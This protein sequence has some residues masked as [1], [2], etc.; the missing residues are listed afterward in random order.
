MESGGNREIYLRRK[1]THLFAVQIRTSL[2]YHK[3]QRE[4]VLSGNSVLSLSYSFG[5]PWRK[6]EGI[7]KTKLML[8][9]GSYE[10]HKRMKSSA[11]EI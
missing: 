9:S 5:I 1:Q 3:I 11:P 8:T 7:I 2:I 6:V 4:D 10:V